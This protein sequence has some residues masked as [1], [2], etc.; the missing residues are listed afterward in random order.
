MVMGDVIFVVW[1]VLWGRV[2]VCPIWDV[3]GLV[4]VGIEVVGWL[5]EWVG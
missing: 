1:I 5:F 4:G 3:C 2:G